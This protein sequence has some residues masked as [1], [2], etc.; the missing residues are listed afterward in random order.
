M[1]PARSHPQGHVDR[2]QRQLITGAKGDGEPRPKRLLNLL[3]WLT[4]PCLIA[5]TMQVCGWVSLLGVKALIVEDT[6][7]KIQADYSPWPF[8]SFLPVDSA[9]LDEISE[10]TGRSINL[11]LQDSSSSSLWGN[12]TP[13]LIETAAG[14]PTSIPLYSQTPTAGLTTPTAT[15]EGT[16]GATPTSTPATT[17]TATIPPTTTTTP[18]PSP[19]DDKQGNQHFNYTS[20]PEPPEPTASGN[21]GSGADDQSESEKGKY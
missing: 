11:N 6:R 14:E 7:A 10:H 5:M 9:I 2:S 17:L 4:L 16:T 15:L 21:N 19:T 13:A 3:G 12:P 1:D 18:P 8:L 20:T